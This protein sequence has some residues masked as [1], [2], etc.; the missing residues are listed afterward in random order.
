MREQIS[1]LER[2]NEEL[3]QKVD[4]AA[5]DKMRLVDCLKEKEVEA[6]ILREDLQALTVKLQATQVKLNETLIVQ[7]H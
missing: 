4:K 5:E 6:R 1:K 3:S 7:Q 2:T